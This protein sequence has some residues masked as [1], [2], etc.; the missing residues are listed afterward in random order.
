MKRIWRRIAFLLL[1]ITVSFWGV[2]AADMSSEPQNTSE[3]YF[4]F[5]EATGT[6]TGYA[7]EGPKDVVIPAT[8]RGVRV[9]KIGEDAFR[10]KGLTSV[11]FPE[12]LKEIEYGA[13]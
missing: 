7:G 13:F 5:D 8:I 2:A 10:G 4:Q 1:L 3:E 6:V 9:R 11:V 12:G